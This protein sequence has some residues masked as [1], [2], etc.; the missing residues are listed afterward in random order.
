MTFIYIIT[1]ICLYIVLGITLYGICYKYNFLDIRNEYIRDKRTNSEDENIV[2]MILF[3]PFI[4]L[5]VLFLCV[6][7]RIIEL[8]IS[9]IND[10][11]ELSNK[12]HKNNKDTNNIN[13]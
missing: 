6:P 13:L 1:F 7:K 9:D 2:L 11:L 12:L 8:L 3:W 5:I 4:S 10:D